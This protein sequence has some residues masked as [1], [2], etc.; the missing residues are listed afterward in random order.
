MLKQGIYSVTKACGTVSAEMVEIG[1]ASGHHLVYAGEEVRTIL[2]WSSCELVT[3]CF[4]LVAQLIT[5]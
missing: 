5:L 3:C 2:W 1:N 4:Q